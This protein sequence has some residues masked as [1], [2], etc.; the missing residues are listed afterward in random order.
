MKG[1][2][3]AFFILLFFTFGILNKILFFYS[4]FIRKTV[5]QRN[6]QWT[7]LLC[8]YIFGYH[9]IYDLKNKPKGNLLICNHM[10]YMDV[11]VIASKF[12]TLFVTSTEM[13]DVPFL[14]WIT[15]IGECLY[16]NRRSHKSMKDEI[17]LI[18]SWIGKGFNVLIFPEATTSDGVTLRPFKSSLLQ[19]AQSGTIPIT[20]Y[21]LKYNL[22]NSVPTSDAD[23]VD[24]IA[25]FENASFLPHVFRQF[26]NKSVGFKLTEVDH[27]LSSEIRERK[28][29]M[30]RLSEKISTEFYTDVPL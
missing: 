15:R 8:R 6:T 27:F 23:K 5:A 29:L 13:R 17:Q 19:I 10:S 11:L 30:N 21:C 22:L 9:G 2:L 12:P 3:I 25:W 20:A 16:V 26:M 14:G 28:G 7:S 1:P 18:Q 24:N 4:P